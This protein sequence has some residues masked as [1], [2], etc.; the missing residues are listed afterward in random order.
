[1]GSS[2]PSDQASG[3]GGMRQNGIGRGATGAIFFSFLLFSWGAWT[4]EMGIWDQGHSLMAWERSCLGGLLPFPSLYSLSGM[5]F[6]RFATP[7]RHNWDG[8]G[9]F[10]GSG[11]GSFRVLHVV[12]VLFCYTP[13]TGTTDRYDYH[14]LFG[15]GKIQRDKESKVLHIKALASLHV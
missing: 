5:A 14:I 6:F 10:W 3:R 4:K 7:W 11:L 12:L 13:S 1:M 15:A 8:S 2:N 9:R